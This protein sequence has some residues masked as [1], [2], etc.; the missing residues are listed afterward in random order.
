MRRPSNLRR[1]AKATWSTSM[2]RPMPIA[3]VATRKSTS[4]D[5]KSATWAL[6]VRGL[7]R[8]HHHRRPAA[9]AAD[10]FGD[11]IDRLG[12][13]GDD[14][15]APRQA[16]Q[17]LRRRRRSASRGARGTGSRRRGRGGGRAERRSPRRA[18]SSRTR[19]RACSRRWVKTWPRSGSAQSWISSTAR[20]STSPLERHRLDRADEILR[21]RRDDLFLAGDQRD[22]APR[23]AP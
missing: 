13:K 23:L 9:M 14:G 8:P 3:S 12:G 20:N 16:R 2:L 10:Q 22:R 15:A 17:L 18:A 1:P 6:R 7:Q 21:M 19:P 5:W 4:P 11:R